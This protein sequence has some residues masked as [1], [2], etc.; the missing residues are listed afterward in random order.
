MWGFL[1]RATV[2]SLLEALSGRLCWAK[3]LKNWT[4]A[5][6]LPLV[7]LGFRG[8]FW[9]EFDRY[10]EI[11]KDLKSTFFFLPLKNVAGTQGSRPAPKRRAAKYDLL[12]IRNEILDLLN[13]GCEVALH[14]IDAWQDVHHAE[15]EKARISEV[16]GQSVVGTRMHWLYWNEDSPEILED[17]GFSYDST[18]GYNDAIGF[19]AGTSQPFCPLDAQQLVE[20]P[21]NIQDSAMFY[22]GRMKLSES[23]AMNACRDLIHSM[24]SSGGALTVNWHTRSLSPERLWGDFYSS[25]LKEIQTHRVWFGTGNEIVRWFRKRRALR[26]DSVEFEEDGARVMLS[27]PDGNPGSAFTVKVHH[28]KYTS[29]ESEFSPCTHIFVESRRGSEQVL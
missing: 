27:S 1:Y 6:S 11:E 29:G 3:C 10:L 7:H 9:L 15:S 16:T 28:P 2:D 24:L 20:L 12:S 17:A 14:G 5:L 13:K 8:D 18:F 19:R 23:E 25:L 21:L 26:F 4:S 22:S